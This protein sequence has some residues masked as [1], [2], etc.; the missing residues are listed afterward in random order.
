MN[1]CMFFAL[2]I[3][4]YFV[5]FLSTFI[6]SIGQAIDFRFKMMKLTLWNVVD[7]DENNLRKNFVLFTLLLSFSSSKLVYEYEKNQ[8]DS[9]NFE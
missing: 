5:V 4:F 6:S 2:F 8:S 1:D 9:V 3:Y 7:S